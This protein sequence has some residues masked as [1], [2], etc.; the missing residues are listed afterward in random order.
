MKKCTGVNR[1]EDKLIDCREL[2]PLIE[3]REN[4]KRCAKCKARLDKG[5]YDFRQQQKK[6]RRR[7]LK[8]IC[9]NGYYEKSVR[10]TEDCV[11]SY[12]W[13]DLQ[14]REVLM[15]KWGVAK[16]KK[17]THGPL[18]GWEY[19]YGYSVDGYFR[20]RTD[21]EYYPWCGIAGIPN[22]EKSSAATE[23]SD[24]IRKGQKRG[25]EIKWEKQWAKKQAE[26]EAKK[27]LSFKRYEA[28]AYN[29]TMRDI[30]KR[31]KG[32]KNK[33]LGFFQMQAAV[34]SISE[35]ANNKIQ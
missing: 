17:V 22:S 2:V 6:W 32:D 21:H 4:E 14:K 34:Q 5:R 26:I 3:F 7:Y 33:G 19:P 18:K 35:Y 30:K 13:R 24:H 29:K 15:I 16:N 8:W 20:L 27:E 25:E 28:W 1:E 12:G 11:D 31:Q 9:K 23:F 10:V